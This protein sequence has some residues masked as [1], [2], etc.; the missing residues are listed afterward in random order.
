[1]IFLSLKPCDLANG[2]GSRILDLPLDLPL[3]VSWAASNRLQGSE[4]Q[5]NNTSS[6]SSSG[7]G[8]HPL[9]W[10]ILLAVGLLVSMQHS[11]EAKVSRPA[12][13]TYDINRTQQASRRTEK[14][15]QSCVFLQTCISL[16]SCRPRATN[17][18]LQPWEVPLG[19]SEMHRSRFGTMKRTKGR[20]QHR[21]EQQR[22]G[23]RKSGHGR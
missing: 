12:V 8:T 18:H 2:V 1:M 7:P 19:Q 6:A 15:C 4:P 17:K 20:R 22:Q 21:T 10:F 23:E 11:A 5:T 16:V 3:A 13:M 9:L 14:S